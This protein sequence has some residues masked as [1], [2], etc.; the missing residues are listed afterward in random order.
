MENRE[1][2]LLKVKIPKAIGAN[3]SKAYRGDRRE[4]KRREHSLMLYDGKR[5][6]RMEMKSCAS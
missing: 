3:R 2:F 1:W 6:V 4:G 5:V